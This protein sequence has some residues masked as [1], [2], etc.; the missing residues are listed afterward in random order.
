MSQHLCVS[1]VNLF[2]HL[3]LAE[4]EQ[5]QQLL[6]HKTYQKGDLI[7]SPQTASRLSIISR[8]KMKVY[9][10]TVSGKEQLLRVAEKGDYEGESQLFGVKNKNLYG[11]A[12]AETTIC[13]LYEKDFQ[14]LRHRFPQLN[15]KLLNLMSQ[16]MNQLEWQAQLLTMDKIEERLACYLINL[17][18]ENGLEDTFKL[19][20][21][22]KE[23]AAFLGTRP[24]TI[25]RKLKHF[26]QAGILE[27]Q[28]KTIHL[29]SPSKLRQIIKE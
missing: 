16:K 15:T 5:V 8:G 12:L 13:I 23:L 9:R 24:E 29:S 28:N 7:L 21:T 26:E 10:L 19:Q 20:M 18:Q 6:R 27:K 1:Y 17:Y 2:N 25:S 22:F 3:D 14:E 11:E 4:Q